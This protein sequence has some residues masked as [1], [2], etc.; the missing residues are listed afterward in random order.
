MVTVKIKYKVKLD[1]LIEF[2]RDYKSFVL[3]NAV[4]HSKII[5]KC[6]TLFNYTSLYNFHFIFKTV[7]SKLLAIISDLKIQ[8][9]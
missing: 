7:P 5:T 1:F 3:I 2:W 4:T 8:S 9:G 6:I